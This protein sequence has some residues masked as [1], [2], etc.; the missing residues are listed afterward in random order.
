MLNKPEAIRRLTYLVV[1]RVDAPIERVD[2]E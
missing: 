2:V 1:G